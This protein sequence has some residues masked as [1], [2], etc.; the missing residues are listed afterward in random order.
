MQ[1]TIT[2]N[3]WGVFFKQIFATLGLNFW[4]NVS[5]LDLCPEAQEH[6]QIF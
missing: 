4:G 3:L 6:R 2:L 5:H 1:L